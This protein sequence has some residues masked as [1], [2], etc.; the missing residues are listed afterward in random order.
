VGVLAAEDARQ[1]RASFDHDTCQ[2]PATLMTL[3]Y[4]A[5]PAIEAFRSARNGYAT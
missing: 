4:G 1:Y 5:D 3:R 2:R